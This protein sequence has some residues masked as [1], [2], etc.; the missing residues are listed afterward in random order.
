MKV[1]TVASMPFRQYLKRDL[2]EKPY[3][4]LK[5]VK[6]SEINVPVQKQVDLEDSI[7]VI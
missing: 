3:P 2:A 1:D 4:A 5:L 7:N 6:T